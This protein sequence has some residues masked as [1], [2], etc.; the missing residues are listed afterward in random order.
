MSEIQYQSAKS[1]KEACKFMLERLSNEDAK[2]R[3]GKEEFECQE[4]GKVFRSDNARAQHLDDT[5]HNDGPRHHAEPQ[6]VAD[7]AKRHHPLRRQLHPPDNGHDGPGVSASRP[8]RPPPLFTALQD[9]PKSGVLWAESIFMEPRPQRK[10][11]SVD[12]LKKC[13]NDANIVLA[14]ARYA[15]AACER[16]WPP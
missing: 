1:V 10:S 16:C 7:S 14:V 3:G 15:L 13:D 8:R 2:R 5:A 12:A 6:I 9:I 11:R 4:C